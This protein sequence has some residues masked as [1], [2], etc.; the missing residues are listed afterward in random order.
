[1]VQH[2]ASKE[3]YRRI[4][5]GAIVCW[6]VI[7]SVAVVALIAALSH[8]DNVTALAK[9]STD[10]A[11]AA[12]VKATA[13]YQAATI[14]LKV[15]QDEAAGECYRVNV[16]RYSHD[17]SAAKAYANDGA[18]IHFLTEA[19]RAATKLVPAFHALATT[20]RNEQGALT[21]QP[22]VD[23]QAAVSNPRHYRTP[24]TIPLG[25]VPRKQLRTALSHPPQPP[26][27]EVSALPPAP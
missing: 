26:A 19:E 12:T 4:A 23:C 25:N 21:F 5:W 24:R 8:A 17:V 13:A 6:A 3:N 15:L 2:R 16:L 7:S 20:F 18:V 27:G 14:A 22:I 1:M 10:K 11:T 9:R